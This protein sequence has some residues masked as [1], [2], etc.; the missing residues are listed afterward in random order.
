[1]VTLRVELHQRGLAALVGSPREC[2]GPTERDRLL[3]SELG[4]RDP[5]AVLDGDAVLPF[6]RTDDEA[7]V[8][9]LQW[10]E[11]IKRVALAIH[12][13]DRARQAIVHRE[14]ELEPS[15]RFLV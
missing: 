6:T 5:L 8:G 4:D 3:R 7:D 10:L 1:L 12:H 13:M 2:H 14:R 9:S 15:I 11:E